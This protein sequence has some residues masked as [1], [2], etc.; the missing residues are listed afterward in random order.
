MFSKIIK[1]TCCTDRFPYNKYGINEYHEMLNAEHIQTL[2]SSKSLLGEFRT[3]G[4]FNDVSLARHSSI[5]LKNVAFRIH[6]INVEDNALV[7]SIEFINDAV[8][9]MYS[10]YPESF[11]FIPRI[12]IESDKLYK[13]VTIDLVGF[14]IDQQ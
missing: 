4:E 7:C 6:S 8:Q 10:M 5:D 1:V 3:Y 14:C 2:L 12:L 9:I 13:L 11:K